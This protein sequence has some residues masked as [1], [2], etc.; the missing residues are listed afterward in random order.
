MSIPQSDIVYD[1]VIESFVAYPIMNNNQNVVCKVNWVY[2]ATYTDPNTQQVY[3]SN[4]VKTSNVSPYN[5]SN[6][7]PYD[8]ITLDIVKQWINLA[9][10]PGILDSLNYMLYQNILKQAIPTPDQT[11]ILPPPF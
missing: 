8:Q 3:T 1:L 10:G 11:V 2:N 6:F 4:F 7:T 9:E 5:I